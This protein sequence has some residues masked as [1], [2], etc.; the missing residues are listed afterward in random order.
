M[1]KVLLS[2]IMGICFVC[3]A[4]AQI[5]LGVEAG[6]S[7]SFM[8]VQNNAAIGRGFGGLVLDVP[9]YKNIEIQTGFDYTSKGARRLT[10]ENRVLIDGH[11]Y[12]RVDM[13]NLLFLELPV[14]VA[15][16][17]KLS[18]VFSLVP[19]FGWYFGVGIGSNSPI[20]V[21]TMYGEGRSFDHYVNR[22]WE[23]PFKQ[24]EMANEDTDYKS[25]YKPFD[26]F[27]HGM[28]FRLTADISHVCINLSY[29]YGLH[30]IW[31]GFGE[32]VKVRGYNNKVSNQCLMLSL[33]YKFF[34]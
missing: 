33:G 3:V 32:P 29:D 11:F 12:E 7:V 20:H 9:V 25:V 31:D 8:H 1:K 19:S 26:R 16:R 6:G 15:Y 5:R 17:F 22:K 27:D 28:Q 2:L 18:R 30:R 24:M 23:N 21:T 14:R 4:N 34:L 10:G 13:I